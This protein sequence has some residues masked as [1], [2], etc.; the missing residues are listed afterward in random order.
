MTHPDDPAASG[1]PETDLPAPPQMDYGLRA[2][3]IPSTASAPTPSAPMP[4][5]R[6]TG[7]RRWLPKAALLVVMFLALAS[8]SF[9]VVYLV[10]R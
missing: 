2:P 1:P 5:R 4:G 8:L 10:F 3:A 9:T 6:A 7:P